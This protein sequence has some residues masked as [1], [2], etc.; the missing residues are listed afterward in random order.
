[1]DAT[2][3]FLEEAFRFTASTAHALTVA[4]GPSMLASGGAEDARPPRTAV[5]GYQIGTT[6]ER[7]I[8]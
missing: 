5:A 2:V 6:P 8:S 1:V 7:V 4:A 3:E